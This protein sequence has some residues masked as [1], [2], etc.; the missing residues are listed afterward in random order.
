[1]TARQ[2]GA[3]LG[4]FEI[5]SRTVRHGSEFAR[6]YV[7]ADFDDAFARYLTPSS[8]T[9]VTNAN[10]AGVSSHAGPSLHRGVTEGRNGDRSQTNDVTNV[11]DTEE[12]HT[13]DERDGNQKPRS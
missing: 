1:M 4:R 9:G 13:A 8:G 7:R 10:L 12:A 5:C 2:L 11:T 6:S 3:R